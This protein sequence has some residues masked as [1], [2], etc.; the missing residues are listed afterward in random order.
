MRVVKSEENLLYW[1]L[2]LC[3]SSKILIRWAITQ[4]LIWLSFT[5]ERTCSQPSAPTTDNPLKL[6][7]FPYTRE[8]KANSKTLPSPY[9]ANSD[10]SR[11]SGLG[12][13]ARIAKSLYGAS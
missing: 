6:G 8:L 4:L 3:V 2:I 10:N 5:C 7:G 1:P 13:C 9:Q 11:P 12:G